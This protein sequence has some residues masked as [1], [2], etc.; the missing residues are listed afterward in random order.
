[1][2]RPLLIFATLAEA[3]TTVDESA[4]TPLNSR[5]WQSLAFDILICGM[6]SHEALYYLQQTLSQGSYSRLINAGCAA[7]LQHGARQGEVF[8]V[9]RVEKI[10]EQLAPH[11]HAKKLFEQLYPPYNLELFPHYAGKVLGSVDCPVHQVSFSNHLS[12]HIQ[13]L[14]M[15]GYTLAWLA[16]QWALP[17]SMIKYVSDFGNSEG[18]V[19]LKQELK[20]AS[21]KL[22]NI[23]RHLE[24]NS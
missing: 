10:L 7:S 17:L 14:D 22:W 21:E 13:L 5:L 23:L 15:E 1:M 18:P 8:T 16:K 6:G 3:Q 24:V 9:Q 20:V 2:T 12:G 4:A 19:M 11:P